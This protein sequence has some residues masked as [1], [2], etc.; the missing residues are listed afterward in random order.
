MKAVILAAGKGNRLRPI[1]STRPKP[2]IPIAGKP[3]L[4]HSIEGLVNAGVNQILLVVG[5]KEEMV[6]DYFRNGKDKFNIDI[7]YITQEEHL[8]T[9]HAAGYAKDFVK[10]DDFL[11]MYG[12][13][14]VNP[15]L[16]NE[17]VSTFEKQQ[18]DGIVSMIEVKDPQNYGIISLDS[19]G[20][21]K[22]IIEKPNANLNVGNLANAGIYLFKSNIFTAIKQ[23][24]KSIRGEYEFTD[25]IE[26]FIEKLNS[27][28]YGYNIKGFYWND[29]GLPWQLLEVNKYV[30]DTQ[31]GKNLGNI[32]KNVFISGE[33]YI[34]EGTIIRSGT[35][36]QGP[37]FIGKNCLIGPNAFIRPYTSIQDNCHVGMS[38][39]KNS[40]IFSESSIPHFNYIGD[41]IICEHVNLGAGTKISNLRFDNKSIA[42]NIDNKMINSE[43][44]KMGAIIGPYCQTG[45]NA[46][47]MCG[48]KVAEYSVIGAHTLVN[49]DIPANTLFYQN[50]KGE[51]IK[52]PNTFFKL[53]KE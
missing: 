7:T 14:F 18:C 3:L 34:G 8:G 39:I 50:S 9:A 30:L 4:E 40:I 5:Y 24:E 42:M 6:K 35:Y 1:T 44:R 38:E 23:T 43:R 33:V 32:E 46:S 48:K 51:L 17:M 36:I 21:I 45:I 28:I 20:Y 53:K 10:K 49:E 27:Q 16:F 22:K 2:L 15:N 41:S 11:L 29:I 37:C 12:D 25:S 47:I 52:K 26:V 19:S 13:L 31:S